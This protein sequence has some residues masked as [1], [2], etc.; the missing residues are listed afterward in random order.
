MSHP[1]AAR[2]CGRQSTGSL[3]AMVVALSIHPWLNT[4][5]DERRLKAAKVVLSARK[6]ASQ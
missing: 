4:K 5:D 1:E 3:R 2:I 6:S